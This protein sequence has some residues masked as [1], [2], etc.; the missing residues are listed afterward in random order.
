MVKI[1]ASRLI[2][3]S[4]IRVHP[5]NV[6]EH[7][8]EQINNLV[9][10]IKWV[11]FKD[12]IVLDKENT[13]RAGHGRLLAAQ[14]LGMDQVPYV[15]LEGL[16]KKQMDLFIYMDNQINESPWIQENV[17]LILE[18]IPLQDLELF[19]IDW[20]GVKK[21]EFEEEKE[22]IPE[23][24]DAPKTKLGDIYLLGEHKLICGDATNLEDVKKVLG[25]L[26]INLL[27]N[28]PPYNIDFSYKGYKDKK[29][30]EDYKNFNKAWYENLKPLA[31]AMIITC[32]PRNIGMWY[33]I[34]P[35][36]ADIG[37]WRERNSSS[38]ASVFNLRQCEPILFYGKFSKRRVYD[39]FEYTAA[40][41]K[42]LKDSQNSQGLL[43][44]KTHAPAKPLKF[45]AEIVRCFTKTNDIVWDNFLGNGTTLLACE[46]AN[47]ICIG[48]E[49]DTAY[50]DVIVQR[51]ENYTGEKARLL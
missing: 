47:R 31:S 6:K 44:T 46:Q 42:E 24:P 4:D 7:P 26:K 28:D 17:E 50:C 41:T 49:L 14:R 5:T 21:E 33:E 11:G 18:D 29:S 23:P 45:L 12:P 39:Y 19:E 2:D 3:I 20:D 8:N 1:P 13:I 40:F 27:F 48:M 37:I 22:A 34:D 32:G 16:T 38:G 35:K 36:V 9:Q 25:D 15:L 43:A 10:L 51:W 30:Y